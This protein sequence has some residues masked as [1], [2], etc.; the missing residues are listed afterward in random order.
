MIYE[1]N[2]YGIRSFGLASAK[3]LTGP[4]EKIT[5]NYDKTLKK[6]YWDLFKLDLL[7]ENKSERD[8]ILKKQILNMKVLYPGECFLCKGIY[9]NFC[10]SIQNIII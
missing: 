4:W 8:E 7:N 9:K 6:A 1:L 2:K 10:C 3:N 5:D